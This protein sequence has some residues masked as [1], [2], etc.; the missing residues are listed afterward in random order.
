MTEPLECPIRNEPLECPIR[1]FKGVRV[2]TKLDEIEVEIFFS[3]YTVI[4]CMIKKEL[5]VD[6]RG[7]GN[8]IRKT[9]LVNTLLMMDHLK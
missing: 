6:H 4:A 3:E 2:R 9:D 7:P 5:D 8:D 1:S